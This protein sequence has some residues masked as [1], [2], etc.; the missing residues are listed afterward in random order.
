MGQTCSSCC[1]VSRT[2]KVGYLPSF[3]VILADKHSTLKE[4][5]RADGSLYAGGSGKWGGSGPLLPGVEVYPPGLE[6]LF[7]CTDQEYM[8]CK[9]SETVTK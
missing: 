1:S 4:G 6:S 2:L 9:S 3:P 5:S 8:C 7:P